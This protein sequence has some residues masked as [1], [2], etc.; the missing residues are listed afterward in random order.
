M[1]SCSAREHVDDYDFFSTRRRAERTFVLNFDQNQR[2]ASASGG[3]RA[4]HGEGSEDLRKELATL[5]R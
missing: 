5:G 2:D 1:P 3:T 4:A